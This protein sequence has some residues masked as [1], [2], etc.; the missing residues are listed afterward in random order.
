VAVAVAVA[1]AEAEEAAVVET[2]DVPALPVLFLEVVAADL[3]VGRGAMQAHKNGNKQ[4][5]VAMAR[6]LVTGADDCATSGFL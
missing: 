1:A 4:N 3:P 6:L 5:I 2:A